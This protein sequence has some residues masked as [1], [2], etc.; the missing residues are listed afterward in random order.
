MSLPQTNKPPRECPPTCD[1]LRRQLHQ[2]LDQAL[3]A[4]QH[5]HSQA[6]FL[7]FEKALLVHLSALGLLLM[8]LFLLVRHQGLDLT[9]CDR[10]GATVSLTLTPRVACTPPAGNCATVAPT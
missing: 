9:A 6:S 2:R 1:E 8:Q 3:D 4:C 5:D 10:Q 7:D